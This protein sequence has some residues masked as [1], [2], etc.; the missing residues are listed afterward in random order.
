MGRRVWFH[1]LK[2]FMFR[3]RRVAD[4]PTLAEFWGAPQDA[5]EEALARRDRPA[6]PDWDA[7]LGAARRALE[8]RL[9]QSG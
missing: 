6:L 4:G 9:R 1:E 7:R 5:E 2:N 3:D 8:Q